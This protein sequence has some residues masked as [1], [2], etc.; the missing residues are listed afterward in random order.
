MKLCGVEIK[1]SKAIFAIAELVNGQWMHVPNETK[2]IALADD[3]EAHNVRSF[4]NLVDGFLRDNSLTEVVVKKRGKKGVFAGGAT[5]FKI[6]GV[7]QLI[8]DCNVKLIA[9]PTIDAQDRKH[10]FPKPATLKMYQREAF[11][12]ACTALAQQAGKK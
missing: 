9:A 5:T 6:E 1:G 8:R 2:Q 3:D 7:F 4:S 10:S 12:V 11:R